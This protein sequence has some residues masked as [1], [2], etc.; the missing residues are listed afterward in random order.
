L[1][2]V[3]GASKARLLRGGTIEMSRVNGGIVLRI[4]ESRRDP[5]DTI[6]VLER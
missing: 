2:D 5:I 4:P 6:V 3:P 1:P